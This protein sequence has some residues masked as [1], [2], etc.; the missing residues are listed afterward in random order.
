MQLLAFPLASSNQ[1]LWQASDIASMLSLILGGISM[2]FLGIFADPA[3]KLSLYFVAVAWVCAVLACA[4]WVALAFLKEDFST[5]W[6]VKVR[7]PA[8]EWPKS[9]VQPACRW[10]QCGH[11][12]QC[13]S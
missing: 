13:R 7:V 4:V 1:F 2:S 5:I 6:P 9:G 11:R 8:N 3:I 12:C 10:G